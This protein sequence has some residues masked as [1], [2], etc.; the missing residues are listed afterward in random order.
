MHGDFRASA[1]NIHGRA[2]RRNPVLGTGSLE[3]AHPLVTAHG[4]GAQREGAAYPRTKS[5]TIETQVGV[6]GL[7]RGRNDMHCARKTTP[8]D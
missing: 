4:S 6:C 3:V 8:E 1:N 2:P 7:R 5:S